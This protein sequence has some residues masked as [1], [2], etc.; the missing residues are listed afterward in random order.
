MAMTVNFI[1]LCNLTDYFCN[2]V[3]T[4]SCIIK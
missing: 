1:F 4:N 3:K 2:E